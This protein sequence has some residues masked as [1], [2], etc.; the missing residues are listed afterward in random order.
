ME[1]IVL[2]IETKA[3]RIINNGLDYY[4]LSQT[5]GKEGIKELSKIGYTGKD[6]KGKKTTFEQYLNSLNKGEFKVERNGERNFRE[7]Y[8]F[9]YIKN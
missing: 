6:L 2:I 1:K 7:Q 4:I 5:I 3:G 9:T 8:I